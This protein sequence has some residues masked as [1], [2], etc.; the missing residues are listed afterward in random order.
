MIYSF[1]LTILFLQLT[2]NVS[3]IVYVFLC[4]IKLYD[5]MILIYKN[6]K[7]K[8]FN[9]KNNINNWHLLTLYNV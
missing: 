9:F 4:I 8:Q 6:V 7:I 5:I 2:L 3:I 1:H